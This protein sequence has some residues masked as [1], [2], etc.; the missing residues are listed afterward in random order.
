MGVPRRSWCRRALPGCRKLRLAFALAFAFALEGHRVAAT[1]LTLSTLQLTTFGKG[2]SLG[3]VHAAPSS[4][5][6]CSGSAPHRPH[7][8]TSSRFHTHRFPTIRS[9]L[10]RN[11]AIHQ[12]PKTNRSPHSRAPP[13]MVQEMS[14]GKLQSI[15]NPVNLLQLLFLPLFSHG[16]KTPFT[17][18]SF[19]YHGTVAVSISLK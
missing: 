19:S 15:T 7:R 16:N 3:L 4:S 10:A 8:Q 11:H 2:S 1:A 12:L 5:L 13:R 9:R 17:P 18:K 6:R 14:L